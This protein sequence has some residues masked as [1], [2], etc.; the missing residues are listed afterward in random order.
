MP[1]RLVHVPV[2]LGDDIRDNSPLPP[3]YSLAAMPTTPARPVFSPAAASVAGAGLFAG[4]SSAPPSVP[5]PSYSLLDGLRR[6]G[7]TPKTR[8][9]GASQPSRQSQA[10][11]RSH[12]SAQQGAAAQLASNPMAL[13]SN[14]L[15]KS[16]GARIAIYKMAIFG[17]RGTKRRACWVFA[18]FLLFWFLLVVA[19]WS[20]ASTYC[21]FYP[22][23]E[24]C[25]KVE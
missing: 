4:P 13:E 19:C 23:T 6:S 1:F 17:E 8:T 10:W 18:L 5:P 11:A 9:A 21:K 24:D 25:E 22:L 7:A 14:T 12:F 2:V 16:R 20:P 3:S 15:L